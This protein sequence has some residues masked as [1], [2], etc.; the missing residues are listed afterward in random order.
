[1]TWEQEQIELLKRGFVIRECNIGPHEAVLVY[2]AKG[3]L[4]E[5]KWDDDIMKYRS[6]MWLKKEKKLISASFPKFFNWGE[7]VDLTPLPTDLK[8]S[9]L[10]EKI[11]GSALI[12][13]KYDKVLIHR[14]RG[15]I[16]AQELPTGNEIQYLKLKYP[17]AFDNKWINSELI[18]LIYEWTSPNNQIVIDYGTDPDIYLV[19][20]IYHGDYSLIEQQDLDSIGKQ[21]NV[22]RPRIYSYNSITDMLSAVQAFKGI[23]GICLYFGE[24]Q[25]QIL[26]VKGA[27]YLAKHAFKSH[28]TLESVI[29]MFLA[30]G[31]P[32]YNEF[33]SQ[34]TTEF[35]YECCQMAVPFVSRV[36]TAYKEIEKIIEHNQKFANNVR[37]MSR[38]D[39]ALS[40][41]KAYGDTNR[42]GFVFKAL[43]NKKLDDKDYKKL[44]FQML[45]G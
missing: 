14:T 27:D 22:K 34:L 2:P 31:K 37:H 13:S 28:C 11:D 3:N 21:I 39:A 42:S 4:F 35:D 6:S 5:I 18:S 10:M 33:I 38:K 17:N 20:G 26:K 41:I 44:F 19:G 29:D 7:H 36:C 24:E 30:K 16:D 1:M 23:E 45:K 32:S 40:I 12:V 25:Q 8:G 15:T 9:V 43:D